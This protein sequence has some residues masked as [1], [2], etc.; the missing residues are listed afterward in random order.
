[1]GRPPYQITHYHILWFVE[2][3]FRLY[4]WSALVKVKKWSEWQFQTR[5]EAREFAL[6]NWPDAQE[7]QQEA[8]YKMTNK[9]ERELPS[10]KHIYSMEEMEKRYHDVISRPSKPPKG[11]YEKIYGMSPDAYQTMLEAQNGLCAI[12]KQPPF[13]NMRLVVDHDHQTGKVRGLLCG[14]CNTRL[15]G[16]EKRLDI[17]KASLAYLEK[18]KASDPQP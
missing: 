7:V 4:A 17:F 10:Q 6:L 14:G 15:G 3:D 8:F 9:R 11:H 12:C 13:Y 1:M 5:E 18:S 16:I 2:N